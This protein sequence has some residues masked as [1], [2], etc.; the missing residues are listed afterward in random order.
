[1]R[2]EHATKRRL[3]LSQSVPWVLVSALLGYLLGIATVYGNWFPYEQIQS[4]KLAIEGTESKEPTPRNALFRAFSP[5]A[6]VVMIGDSITS[7]GE[8]S[9]IFP[10]VRISNRG[11]SGETAEDILKRMDTIYAVHPDKAFIMVGIND[12]YEGQHV[13]NIYKNYIRIVEQLRARHI[14]V[15]IQSTIECSI[16]HCGN[17]VYD[18]RALN[19]RLEAYAKGNGITYINL[20]ERLATESQGLLDEYTYDGMHLRAAGFVQWKAMIQPYVD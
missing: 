12:I 17:R 9:E 10:N 11:I 13:D 4:M 6:D 3:T 19:K 18:V 16:S 15:Y 5:K 20:N 8:W 14:K 2:T 7:A 1:M